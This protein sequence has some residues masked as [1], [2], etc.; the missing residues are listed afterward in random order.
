MSFYRSLLAAV[1]AMGLA[2]AVFADDAT[3][4]QAQPA[5][6]ANTAQAAPAMA[7][8]TKVDINKATA[9]DLAKVKGLDANKAKAIVAYRK[10]HGEFKSV[11]DLKMVKGFKRMKADHFQQIQ[12]QLTVG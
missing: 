1:A 7:E 4:T 10:K 12:D 3:A 5:A 6:N 8:Q 11:D 2:G 9:K